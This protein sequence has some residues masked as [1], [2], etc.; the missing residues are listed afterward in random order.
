[1]SV[2]LYISD[3]PCKD[4]LYSLGI[5]RRVLGVVSDLGTIGTLDS[6][7]RGLLCTE[8][9]SIGTDPLLG[10]GFLVDLVELVLLRSRLVGSL[11]GGSSKDVSANESEIVQDLSE[12]RVGD[13]KSNQ[14]S[15]V[16]GG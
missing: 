7:I 3:A 13:E 16:S 12:F 8:L 11:G 6:D 5:G 14:H 10:W 4:A 15:E 1:M 2:T 9:L